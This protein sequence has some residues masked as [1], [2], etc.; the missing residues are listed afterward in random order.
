MLGVGYAFSILSE[1]YVSHKHS[2][3][4]IQAC[5][6][7]TGGL[8]CARVLTRYNKVTVEGV[9]CSLRWAG[10]HVCRRQ[11]G[12]AGRK[13][14]HTM[15]HTSM[16]GTCTSGERCAQVFLRDQSP[17]SETRAFC[18]PGI[19]GWP[20]STRDHISVSLVVELIISTHYHSQLVFF[21]CF[22]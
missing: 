12:D 15:C 13:S 11:S 2:A 17:F 8:L 18:W 20:L 9:L 6:R 1:T 3:V 7:D 16:H 10:G 22:G 4:G 21:F 14:P 5:R 19:L